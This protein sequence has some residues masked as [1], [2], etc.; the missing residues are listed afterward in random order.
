MCYDPTPEHGGIEPS[1]AE[2]H[3]TC[4]SPEYALNTVWFYLIDSIFLQLDGF[5]NILFRRL[6]V[7]YFTLL[8]HYDK[9]LT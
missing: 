4:V 9:L 3:E 8:V 1:A 5:N 2:V 7:S 6:K